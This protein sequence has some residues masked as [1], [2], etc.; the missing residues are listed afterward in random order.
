MKLLY[1]TIWDFQKGLSDGVVKK[2]L[3]YIK[4]FEDNG[5]EVDYTYYMG[6]ERKLYFHKENKDI[7][8]GK[9]AYIKGIDLRRI[10]KNFVRENRYEYVY[11]RNMGRI[12]KGIIA[13]LRIIYKNG[14]KIFYEFPTFPYE[15]ES[16]SIQ[17]RLDMLIDR[18]YR[19]KMKPYIERVITYSE[20]K[21]I[22][23]IQTISIMNGIAVKDIKRV[24]GERKDT[25]KIHVLAVARMQPYDGYEKVIRGMAEYLAAGGRKIQVH[26]VGDGPEKENYVK[27]SDDLKLDAVIRFYD[28]LC[29]AKLDEMYEMADMTLEVFGRGKQGIKVSSSLK[30]RESVA[31]GLPIITGCK[32]DMFQKSLFPYVIQFSEDENV[33]D[34][35]RVEQFYETITQNKTKEEVAI[36]I[37]QFAEENVDLSKTLQPIWRCIKGIE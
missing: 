11:I 6:N 10:V 5:F 17:F 21:F 14:G 20:D 37:R 22:Y 25:D 29:G 36:E 23:G 33:V 28:S 26:F 35:F 31:R 27:L 4:A 2:I 8:I 32:I 34:M 7:A 30:S 24:S 16:K 1:L 19:K 12:D 18:I 15:Y 13:I 9:S 3:Q